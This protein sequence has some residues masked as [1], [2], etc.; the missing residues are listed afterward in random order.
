[1]SQRPIDDVLDPALQ[2]ALLEAAAPVTPPARLRA[3]VLARIGA[4][5]W[6]RIDEFMEIKTL[7]HDEAA[8]MV[9]FL[10]RAQPGASM[11][12]HVHH[13]MEECLVLE[14]E[15]A[16]G[17][18]TLYPGDFELGRTGEQHP[19]ATT[20]T[21]VVVYLRGAVEDYPFAVS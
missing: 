18:R 6:K 19:V 2:T 4:G 21:G 12:A 5:D 1:M 17:E 7:H 9:S 8:R 10:V 13:A 16:L 14:G 20:R 3:R 11:P 15:F